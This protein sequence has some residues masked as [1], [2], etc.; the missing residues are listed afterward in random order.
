[1][2]TLLGWRL[3]D[4]DCGPFEE[5]TESQQ[6]LR[7]GEVRPGVTAWEGFKEFRAVLE[8]LVTRL[9]QKRP[10]QSPNQPSRRLGRTM[11]SMDLGGG[12]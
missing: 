5:S 7:P 11:I 8:D 9:E 1:M 6:G 2:S 10:R 3:G 4:S 12:K